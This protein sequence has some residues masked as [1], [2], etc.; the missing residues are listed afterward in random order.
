MKS[1]PLKY[2]YEFSRVYKRGIFGVAGTVTVHA[3]RRPEG[4][5]H[6]MTPIPGDII[7]VGFCAN[8]RKLGAV[9]RN[10]ARRLMR[11][12]Y[13]LLEDKI[14]RGYDIV[15]TL[16]STDSVP[17]YSDVKRDIRRV[18]ERIGLVGS[19]KTDG[20]KIP[21]KAG[22]GISEVHLPGSGESL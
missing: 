12:A 9:G 14:P 19:E 4:L 5:K 13:R 2:N 16:R 17:A 3:F 18:F 1:V 15:I 21:D 7:R 22:E 11:E 8:K 20:S 10:R 6:Y